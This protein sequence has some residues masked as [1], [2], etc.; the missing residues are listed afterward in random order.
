MLNW[1]CRRSGLDVVSSNSEFGH[2]R[3]HPLMFAAML[4]LPREIN[5]KKV[6]RSRASNIMLSEMNVFS[7]Y[8]MDQTKDH[9]LYVK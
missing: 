4:F 9:I 6:N 7:A 5:S 2:G 3:H 8:H 1:L